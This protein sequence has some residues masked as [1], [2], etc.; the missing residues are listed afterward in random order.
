M[1]TEAK[2][3]LIK[4]YWRFFKQSIKCNMK[5]LLEYRKSFLIQSIFMFL[6]NGFFLIIWKVILGASEGGANSFEF[7]DLLYLWS[8]PTI[9][10]G[11][12]FFFF[13]GISDLGKYIME[14]GLDTYLI[15]PKNLLINVMLSKMDFSAFGD[16]V[17]GLVVGLFA[18]QFDM[19]KYLLLVLFGTISSIF[20]ICFEAII[21]LSSI[22]IGN[23]DNIEHLLVITILIGTATYPEAIYTGVMKTILYTIIPTAYVAF[24]PIKLVTTFN[25]SSL[26]LYFAAMVVFISIT[27]I[28]TKLVVTKYESG[29]TMVMRG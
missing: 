24:V 18:T 20:F 9:G 6:N 19:K 21:R 3:N 4:S 28:M 12:T 29:N 23:T 11:I 13:A 16:L 7:T 1:S 26:I 5:S 14:G 8:I 17:Y 25:I 22:L 15:Q 27:I 10:F 2:R